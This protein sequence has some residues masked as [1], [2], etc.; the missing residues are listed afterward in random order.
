L[1]DE[2]G[3]VLFQGRPVSRP[4]DR[5]GVRALDEELDRVMLVGHD[6]D[7]SDLAHRLPSEI[8]EC[9]PALRR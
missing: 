4:E 7:F 3:Y 9:P 6:P 8:V 2:V 5:H 1:L